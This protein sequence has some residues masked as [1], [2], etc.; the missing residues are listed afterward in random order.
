M[1]RL[2][3][4][5]VGIPWWEDVEITAPRICVEAIT[6]SLAHVNKVSYAFRIQEEDITS[7]NNQNVIWDNTQL[8]A[9]LHNITTFVNRCSEISLILSVI[10]MSIIFFKR[11]NKPQNILLKMRNTKISV[12]C[13]NFYG[14]WG[15]IFTKTKIFINPQLFRL[16]NS[17]VKLSSGQVL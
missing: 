2:N 9:K 1:P 15:F 16:W 8:N 6:P 4:K 7:L 12:L 11:Y 5:V 13:E 3:A 14:G 17:L 10:F